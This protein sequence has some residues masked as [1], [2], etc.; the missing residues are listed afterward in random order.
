MRKRLKERGDKSKRVNVE[1]EMNAFVD[2]AVSIHMTAILLP[3][4][5]SLSLATLS[6]A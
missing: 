6:P 3:A 1:V 5:I 4:L 2:A